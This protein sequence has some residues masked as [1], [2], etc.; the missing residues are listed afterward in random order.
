MKTLKEYASEIVLCLFE[1]VVG[2]LLLINPVGFTAGIIKVAGIALMILGLAS[3]IKYFRISADEAI[4]GQSL[5]IGLLSLL[6]GGFCAFKSEWFIITFPVLA[7]IY[8]ILILV[9][10]ISKVQLAVDMLRLKNQNWSWAAINAAISIVCAIVILKSPF[11][12]VSVLWVFTGASLITEGVLDIV[13][14][15]MRKK[16]PDG[17]NL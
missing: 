16:N 2:I 17:N 14:I 6:A 7:I 5:T 15:I 11:I 4:L 9:T 10:G 13:T 8:G 3:V 1:L 12:S